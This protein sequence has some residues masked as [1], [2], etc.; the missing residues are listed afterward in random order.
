MVSWGWFYASWGI[1]TV[2]TWTGPLDF[3]DIRAIALNGAIEELKAENLNPLS[4]LNG[5]MSDRYGTS[6][7]SMGG[8]GT[9]RQASRDPWL[10]GTA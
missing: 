5:Q 10:P 4:P 1:V 6:G 3:P 8:G 2:V 7:Y 9:T